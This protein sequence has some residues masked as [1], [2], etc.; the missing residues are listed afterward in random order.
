MGQQQ[1]PQQPMQMPGQGG[2]QMNIQGNTQVRHNM[3]TS[4]EQNDPLFMLK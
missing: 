2:M 4:D 1:F 3:A